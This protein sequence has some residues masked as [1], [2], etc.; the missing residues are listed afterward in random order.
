MHYINAETVGA[1][2]RNF[3]TNER[4]IEEVQ[5]HILKHKLSKFINN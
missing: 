1:V 2:P 3:I 4:L 5:V